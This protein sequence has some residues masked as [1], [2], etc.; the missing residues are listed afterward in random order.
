VAFQIQD[1]LLNLE[2]EVGAY[3][4][5]IAGDLEEG[6][7]TLILLHLLRS[8]GGGEREQALAI[9]AKER[10]QKRPED[11]AWLLERIRRE[12][13]MDH[14][15]RIALD[16][17]RKAEA[18][19]RRAGPWLHASPHLDFLDALIGFVIHRDR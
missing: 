1:D 18:A 7:R 3:G 12:R 17:A 14:A 2:A 6:K 10:T 4:K 13:S 11:I 19:L 15:R 5:E 8:L 16:H 9:L